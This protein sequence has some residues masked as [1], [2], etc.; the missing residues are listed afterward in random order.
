MQNAKSGAM[1]GSEA[2]KDEGHGQGQTMR[3]AEA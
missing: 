1:A 2:V 3:G